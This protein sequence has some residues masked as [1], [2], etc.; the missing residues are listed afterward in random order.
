MVSN[1]DKNKRIN[2]EHGYLFETELIEKNS[3][4]FKEFNKSNIFFY[5][6]KRDYE[7][8]LFLFSYSLISIEFITSF[9]EITL[10]KKIDSRER[11]IRS[12]RG[13]FEYVLELRALKKPKTINT[14]LRQFFWEEVKSVLN[15]RKKNGLENF[16]FGKEIA[17]DKII[18]KNDNMILKIESIQLQSALHH[19]EQEINELKSRVNTM[20]TEISYLSESNSDANAVSKNIANKEELLDSRF[21]E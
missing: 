8:Y 15:Q 6:F 1:K 7:Y 18:L 21:K 17:N 14:N 11:K 13:L 2:M 20:E 5:Y 4:C 3:N 19:L 10:L 9:S 16:L 12:L